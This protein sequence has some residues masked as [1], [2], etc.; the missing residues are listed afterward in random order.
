MR[1]IIILAFK[2]LARHKK[3]TIITSV[4][5]SFGIMLLI[6]I[7]G[8]LKWADNESQRN[9][10]RYE[11]GN[12]TISTKAYKEDRDSF[13]V[14]MV[15]N[16]SEIQKIFRIAEKTGSYAS[17]RTGFKSMMSY[18][19]G[20]GLPYI[21]FAIDPEKD[22]QVFNIKEKIMD[23][24]YLDKNSEGILISAHCRKELGAG[25]GDYLV[26]ETRT[27]YDT[28]QALTIKVVGI[29]DCPDPVVNRNHL[30]ITRNMAEKNL[31]LEG[32]AAEIAFR[33]K[34]G[35][36]EPALSLV[37]ESLSSAG[38]TGL[39]TETWQELGSDYLTLS[40]TKKGGSTMIIF[41]IFI[42]VAVGIIN[43]MLMA[44]FERIR[45][46]GMLRALGVRDRDI[47]SSF[48][49][50]AAGIGI[51]GSLIGLI[52]GIGVSAYSVYHGLDF[53]SSFKDMDYGY[54]TGT[55]FY[56]EWNPEMMAMAVIF[57]IL[58]SVL[59]SIIPARKAV[60]M[61]ITDSIRYI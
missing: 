46:I 43:T 54:R 30:F 1:N 7:H 58:C 21:V 35:N 4:A 38:L 47:V 10:K 9:L 27:K 3:R 18:K 16:G 24:Q 36:N 15:I 42:I 17:P 20:F 14:D 31:Q 59:V 39:T 55:I 32:T 48:I 53:T 23:G 52:L 50:E 60:K 28:F 13:P 2:N 5:I 22:A 57:G 56:N 37:K 61:E 34:N 29:Y 45:E 8:M 6:W 41:F 25:L 51:L 44:V 11:F 40:Q 19:R 12:F 33:T 26:M 49:V